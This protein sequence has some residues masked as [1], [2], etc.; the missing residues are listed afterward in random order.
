MNN[1]FSIFSP[2]LHL[3]LQCF[4]V[5]S[6]AKVVREKRDGGED[7]LERGEDG[8]ERGEEGGGGGVDRTMPCLSSKSPDLF[9][10]VLV[11]TS[12]VKLKNLLNAFMVNKNTACIL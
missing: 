9:A 7:G 8:S 3:S 4:E 11:R 12:E 10:N 1:L 5:E 6:V 2:N